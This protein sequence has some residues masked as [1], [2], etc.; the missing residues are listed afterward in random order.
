M[1]PLI[2]SEKPLRANTLKAPAMCSSIHLRFL[3]AEVKEGMPG[4]V[5]PCEMAWMADLALVFDSVACEGSSF[6]ATMVVV[7]ED[8][9]LCWTI[10]RTKG[11]EWCPR[12][13]C[14]VEYLSMSGLIFLHALLTFYPTVSC[15]LVDNCPTGLAWRFRVRKGEC[16][17]Q[18][19]RHAAGETCLAGQL[20]TSG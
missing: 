20:I 7:V 12:W 19:K 16:N 11:Y 1:C 5:A 10:Q 14:S 9:V 2:P 18:V 17:R 13:R 15:D 3:S 8:M 4:R 6:F